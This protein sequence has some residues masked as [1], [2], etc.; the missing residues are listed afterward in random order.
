MF[1]KFND[2]SFINENVVFTVCSVN[3]LAKA[4][5]LMQSI[6]DEISKVIFIADSK[7]KLEFNFGD[8]EIVFTED[9]GIDRYHE[10]AF[11]YNIIEFNTCVKPYI[12][13]NLLNNFQKVI[14]LDPDIYVYS[15]LNSVFEELKECSLLLTPHSFSSPG[16]NKRPSD[17]D[18]LKF[19]LYNLG[20][21]ACKRDDNSKK[22]LSWWNSKLLEECFYEPGLGMGVDQKVAELMPIFFDGVKI[23]NNLGLNLAFWNL[24]E[25]F[26]NK[27]KNVYFVNGNCKLVFA[28][29]SSYAGPNIVASKQTRFAKGDRLDFLELLANYETKL[30]FITSKLNQEEKSYGYDYVNGYLITPLARRYYHHMIKAGSAPSNPFDDL[31]FLK[32]LKKKK[33]IL[34]GKFSTSHVNFNE[35][36]SQK[37]NIKII[38]FM[39]RVVLKILGP[40]RYY[41]FCTYINYITNTLNQGKILRGNKL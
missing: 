7:R 12:A 28:H 9:I 17:V 14:Y 19:G 18:L 26:V 23:S 5:V 36:S 30:E 24:H 27:D 15:S 16:D 25:R 3:Y 13:M 4:I 31:G 29:F 39:F 40:I 21:F 37:N 41:Y 32:A 10:L 11:K 33:F 6:E 1:N 22:A 35:I 34:F 8:I 2:S 38:A 20:F